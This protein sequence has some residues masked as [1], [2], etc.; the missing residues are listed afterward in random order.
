VVANDQIKARDLPGALQETLLKLSV[1]EATPPFGSIEDGVRVLLLCGRDD[2][3]VDPA[4]AS[5]SCS[6]R[7]KTIAS[8]SARRPIC[9][10]CGATR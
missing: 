2:P 5:T 8:T 9:A 1:G 6:S 4:P 7:W 3:K 10:I